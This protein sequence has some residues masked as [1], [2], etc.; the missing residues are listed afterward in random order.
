MENTFYLV[1]VGI[2]Q[3]SPE[4]ASELANTL[5]AMF[6]LTP[7]HGKKSEFAGEFFECMRSPYLGTHGHIA[8]GTSNLTSAVAELRKKGFSFREDTAEYD[9]KGEL[10]N[11][12]LDGEYGGFSIHI[13]KK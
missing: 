1:H 7:R 9:E 6:N 3:N 8:M 12:Y 2:H 4:E 5:C 10:K 13:L 11:V